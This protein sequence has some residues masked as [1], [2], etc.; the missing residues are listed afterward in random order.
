MANQLQCESSLSSCTNTNGSND[1]DA[2]VE[3]ASPACYRGIIPNANGYAD[4]GFD[5]FLEQKEHTTTT[6]QA[7]HQHDTS[8]TYSASSEQDSCNTRD[9][10]D[11]VDDDDGFGDFEEFSSHVS[12]IIMS[13]YLF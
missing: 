3:M 2:A 12:G 4:D 11:A 10:M 8:M 5:R 9:G 7:E 13:G 1:N 6:L